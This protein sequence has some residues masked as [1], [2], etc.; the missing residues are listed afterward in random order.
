MGPEGRL[1]R[2]IQPR[3]LFVSGEERIET[4]I[5]VAYGVD[6]EPALREWAEARR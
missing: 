3:W 6:Q 1:G 4:G 2:I 5:P